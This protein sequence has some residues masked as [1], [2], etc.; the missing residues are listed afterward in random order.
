ME[1]FYAYPGGQRKTSQQV[2]MEF[3]C[4]PQFFHTRAAVIPRDQ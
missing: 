3:F 1:N 4:R 2:I